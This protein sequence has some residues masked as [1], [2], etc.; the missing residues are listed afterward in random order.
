MAFDISEE[1]VRLTEAEI[2]LGFPPV[3]RS[4][5]MANNGGLAFDGMDEWTLNP[6]KD[7]SDRKRLSRSCNHVIVETSKAKEWRGFPPEGLAIGSSGSGDIILLMPSPA[8]P[9]MLED[10]ILKFDHETGEL[11]ELAADLSK[12]EIE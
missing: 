2:G 10:K 6:I 12:F 8:D 3:Y 11:E 9:G 7:S 1:Q 4:L 5:M